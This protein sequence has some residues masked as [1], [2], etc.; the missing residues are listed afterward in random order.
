MAAQGL[1]DLVPN[2]PLALCVVALELNGDTPNDAVMW[3]F[4]QG[5]AYL[6]SNAETIAKMKRP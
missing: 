2:F 5:E 6:E 4:D 1:L 3:L